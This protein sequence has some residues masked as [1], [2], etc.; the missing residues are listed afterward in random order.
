MFSRKNWKELGDFIQKQYSSVPAAD[1]E[2]ELHSLL[3][4]ADASSYVQWVRSKG[5]NYKDLSEKT[6]RKLYNQLLKQQ[7]HAELKE[8]LEFFAEK[9]FNVEYRSVDTVMFDLT[10]DAPLRGLEQQLIPKIDLAISIFKVQ[11]AF[12]VSQTDTKIPY[13]EVYSL[14]EW[15]RTLAYLALDRKIATRKF[16]ALFDEIFSNHWQSISNDGVY[17]SGLFLRVIS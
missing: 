14:G 11:K 8:L 16:L 5:R 7:R 4:A 9:G 15:F 17:G 6:L 3:I 1:L 10:K 2:K 12:F 13:E